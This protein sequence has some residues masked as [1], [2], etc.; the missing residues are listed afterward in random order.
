M[1][2]V[3]RLSTTLRR[4]P[5]AKLFSTFTL[6]PTIVQK[7]LTELWP[8]QCDGIKCDEIS[9]R[10]AVMSHE[11]DAASLRPGG[12]ISGPRQFAMAD[13]GMWVAVWGALDR[14]EP[15]ALTSELSI[16]FVRPAIGQVLHSR[17][18]VNA[19]SGRSLVCTAVVWTDESDSARPC[20]IA[21]GTYVLPR[22]KS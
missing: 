20:S 7:G 12:Y 22:Q 6:T 8:E 1:S 5:G 18:D 16:R 15:M 21:Q 13:L 9:N 4:L 17:I 11:V 2:A 19:V 3:I 14:I 10:H